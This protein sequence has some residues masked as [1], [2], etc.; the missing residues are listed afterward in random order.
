MKAAVVGDSVFISGFEMVGFEGFEAKSTSEVLETVK[1]IIKMDKYGLILVPE[2][3]TN[4]TKEIRDTLAKEGKVVPT[5]SFLPDYTGIKGERVEE[6]KRLISLALGV[7][8][9]L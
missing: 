5:F 7:K 4:A 9:E 6:L 1:K 2:R 3:Y 8:L